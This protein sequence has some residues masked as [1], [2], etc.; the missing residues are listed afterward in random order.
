MTWVVLGH[1]LF[2]P[3]YGNVISNGLNVYQEWPVPV[4]AMIIINGTLSVDSFFFL[5]ASLFSFLFL[6]KQ[7]RLGQ[8]GVIL[9]L[10]YLRLTVK[11]KLN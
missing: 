9:I 7:T 11:Y 5:S 3:I 6:K 10:R 8:A 4:L 2:V 1:G